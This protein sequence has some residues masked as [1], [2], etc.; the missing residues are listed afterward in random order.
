MGVGVDISM[1]VSICRVRS[2][3][4]LGRLSGQWQAARAQAPGLL[5]ASQVILYKAHPASRQAQCLGS[6]A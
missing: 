5:L 4:I 2:N 6:E 1:R 3:R